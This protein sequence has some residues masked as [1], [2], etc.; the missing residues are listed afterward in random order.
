MSKDNLIDLSKK[1]PPSREVVQLM[2]YS[3]DLDFLI[4]KYVKA[5]IKPRDIAAVQAMI[6]GRFLG[7]FTKK[8][9]FYVYLNDKI[10]QEAG[11]K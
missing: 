1:R 3:N 8:D 9:K 7:R 6:L 10:K 2:N 4:K 5:G 11:L